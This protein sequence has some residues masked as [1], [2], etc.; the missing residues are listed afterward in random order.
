MHD[1]DH[2]AEA[3][4]AVPL[5][6]PPDL[7]RLE[8]LASRR[9]H[10]RLVAGAVGVAMALGASAVALTARHN[11]RA[12]R[13][14]TTGRAGAPLTAPAR[15]DIGAAGFIDHL[16]QG[17]VAVQRLPDSGSPVASG[18]A[19]PLGV[20]PTDICLEHHTI[21]VYEYASRDARVVRSQGISRDGSHITL[22][23]GT[24]AVV[25]WIAAPRFFARGRIIVLYLGNARYVITELEHVLGPTLSPDAVGPAREPGGC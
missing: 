4:V 23:G 11:D 17:G 5:A 3:A 7:R 6:P 21:H 16:R 2:L 14:V 18:A 22:G 25:D 15:D 9:R 20:T 1:L 10:R 24:E 13:V 19:T 12:T 8:A